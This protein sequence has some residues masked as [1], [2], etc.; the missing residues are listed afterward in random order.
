VRSSIGGTVLTPRL[1]DLK[2]RFVTAG[3]TLAEVGDC[4]TLQADLEFTERR[5]DEAAPGEEVSAMF[6]G[7]PLRQARGRIVSI[8]AAT[9]AQPGTQ[10]SGARPP[11]APVERPDR[12]VARAEFDNA[13]GTLRPGMRG[14]AKIYGRRSSPLA[15]TWRLLRRWLQTIVW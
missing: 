7:R 5:L 14:K 13:D 2:G 6:P 15:N 1:E 10:T 3:T 9:L 8:S 4:R 11:P 12:F